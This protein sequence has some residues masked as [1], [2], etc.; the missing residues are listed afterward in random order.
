MTSPRSRS[1]RRCD[2]TGARASTTSSCQLFW[3]RV[4]VTIESFE[5]S[6]S[7]WL[8]SNLCVEVIWHAFSFTF[9]DI[10]SFDSV[11]DLSPIALTFQIWHAC[12]RWYFADVLNFPYRTRGLQ[13]DIHLLIVVIQFV[14]PFGQRADLV[15]QGDIIASKQVSRVYWLSFYQV[16]FTSF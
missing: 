5:L 10:V 3:P 4:T 11:F 12:D 16:G 2:P 9:G 7:T 1:P 6:D 13:C 14:E 8:N 15:P